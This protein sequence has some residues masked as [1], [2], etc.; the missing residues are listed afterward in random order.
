MKLDTVNHWARPRWYLDL[1]YIFF[2]LGDH[3][4]TN[5]SKVEKNII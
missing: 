4:P 3:G 1:N 5:E 2:D